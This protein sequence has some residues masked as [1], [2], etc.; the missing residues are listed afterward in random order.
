MVVFSGTTTYSTTLSKKKCWYDGRE[1]TEL[2]HDM[3]EGR[4]YGQL[5]DLISDRRRQDSKLECTS[6]TQKPAANSRRLKKKMFTG[7]SLAQLT[8][9]T[10]GGTNRNMSP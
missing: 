5:K 4:D 2:L 10:I 3:I 8:V 6:E 9:T 7:I 1:K